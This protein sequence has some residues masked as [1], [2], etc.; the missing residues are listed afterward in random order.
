[1]SLS[2]LRAFQEFV[3]QEGAAPTRLRRAFARIEDPEELVAATVDAAIWQGF[4]V[5]A[6]DVRA[7]MLETRRAWIE[8]W[9][10]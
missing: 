4:D 2:G 7:A 5:Q 8:R 1:M 9:I 3:L 10:G 6:A